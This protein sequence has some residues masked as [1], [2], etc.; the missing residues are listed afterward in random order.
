M[1][2][3]GFPLAESIAQVEPTTKMFLASSGVPCDETPPLPLPKA[4]T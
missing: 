2:G 1:E 3:L 4:C